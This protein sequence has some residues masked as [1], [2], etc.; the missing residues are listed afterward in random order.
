L[1]DG[2]NFMSAKPLADAYE[3]LKELRREGGLNFEVS[4]RIGHQLRSMHADVS[5][6]GVPDRFAELIKK[7]DTPSND[8][9]GK[10][11]EAA[12]LIRA[13]EIKTLADRVFADEEKAEAW[14]QRPNSALWGQRPADLLQDELGTAVV[15]EMLEQIDYGIFA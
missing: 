13:L 2:E 6:Q 12:E 9:S 10:S 15:R 3:R 5:R 4:S 14:L 11:Q 8:S 1:I 7:L